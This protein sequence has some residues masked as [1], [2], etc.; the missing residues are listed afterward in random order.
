MSF[1][2]ERPTECVV[3]QG[4]AHIVAPALEPVRQTSI[5][6]VTGAAGELDD[7]FSAVVHIGD[8]RFMGQAFLGCTVRQQ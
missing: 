6:K 4:P 8:R 7:G 3:G 5:E 2:L 1:T